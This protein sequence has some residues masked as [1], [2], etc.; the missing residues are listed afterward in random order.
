[1]GWND[2]LPVDPFIP[3]SDYYQEQDRYEAWLEYV[4]ARAM[5]ADQLTSQN[6]DPAQLKRISQQETPARRTL[7]SRLWVN[8]FGDQ[9][10][11]ETNPETAGSAA[12]QDVPF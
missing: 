2:R 8:I 10:K 7:F 5:E 12:N 1:M 3:S 9:D 11:K 6:V 4:T